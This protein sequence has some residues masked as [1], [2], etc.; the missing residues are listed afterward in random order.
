MT[1]TAW[2]D[3]LP[4]DGAGVRLVDSPRVRDA[5]DAAE[6]TR[7]LAAI[8]YIVVPA[9]QDMDVAAR[10]RCA[11][12]HV[13]LI[14]DDLVTPAAV[15]WVRDLT[16]A[17]P[18]AHLV[19]R[20]EEEA[21]TM[22]HERALAWPA[23]SQSSILTPR[24]DVRYRRAVALQ[25]AGRHDAARTWW[26]A[27][28]AAAAR[29]G[30]DAQYARAV[31]ACGRAA[32]EH[33]TADVLKRICTMCRAALGRITTLEARA[34]VVE[35][36]A[37]A[38]IRLGELEWTES[39][40]AGVR[41]ECALLD[42]EVPSSISTLQADVAMWQGRWSDAMAHVRSMRATSAAA[43]GRAA[44]IAWL[45][46]DD[47]EMR[48]VEGQQPDTPAPDSRD[49]AWL[50]LAHLLAAA[51]RGDVAAVRAG[52][53]VVARESHVLWGPAAAVEALRQVGCADD[54][55]VLLRQAETALDAGPC[56]RALL[57]HLAG[58][59]DAA[60]RIARCGAVGIV[61]WGKR[62]EQMTMWGGVSA[63]LDDVN[64]A[65]DDRAAIR[66]G[67]RW[68][69]THTG[70]GRVLVLAPDREQPLV[71]DPE[72]AV[73]GDDDVRA[74][75]RQGGVTIG[76]VVAARRS[77]DAE[78]LAGC[79]KTLAAVCAP[80]VRACLDVVRVTETGASLMTDLLGHS[81]AMGAL[82]AA[83]ARAAPTTFPVLIEGE[84]GVGKE[85]VA[86]A[87]HRLSARRDR[88]LAALNC[89][90]LTDELFEAELFG[91]TRGAF[92][93]AVGVRTGLFE[94]AHQGTLFLDE[95]G[96]L[97]PRAQAKLLRVL[98][99]GEVRRV[100]DNQTRAVDVRVVSATNRSLAAV[101][102]QGQY[103]E[104]L[105]F[106]LAVVRITVPPLRDRVEDIPGLAQTFWA[107]ATQHRATRA[108][109]TPDGLAALCRHAWP[110]NVRELQN[111]MAGLVLAAPD[112]G[113]VTAR[114]VAAVLEGAAAGHTTPPGTPLDE[115]R[116]A[117]DR[118]LVVA[119]LA[120]HAGCRAAAARD[121]GVSR[122]G[123]AKLMARLAVPTTGVATEADLR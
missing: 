60:V 24:P 6:R 67:C 75:I 116:R 16:M 123:L 110:G 96:E 1:W 90:A 38:S 30:D 18:R 77:R 88:R 65:E 102:A 104:D 51:A 84:S 72:G 81:P 79:V 13:A 111:V 27:A 82:R 21:P 22:V 80:A 54:A 122:Q 37:E 7:A 62:R 36:W 87:L 23:Q 66:R 42:R 26:Q 83:I 115:A 109:L 11:H 9:T 4:T 15:Q 119:A 91:H 94:D 50:R 34:R 59:A 78:A 114:H 68:V 100:G 40:L 14:V 107:R 12:Q 47:V 52:A 53:G 105:V 20:T 103:R 112:R 73:P 56:A 44:L 8:G 3:Q 118:Q 49:A 63:L 31:W 46:R 28:V 55:Q 69:R 108:W 71:A 33:P 48:R 29:R 39:W 2:A 5:S 32:L 41:V 113:R 95:V 61:H 93:G 58:E 101:A 97:S 74:P 64:N 57:A 43:M 25:R 98:Q 89:A 117:L 45:R 70:T 106:R 17:S 121:L 19:V 120:R 92:T 35:V 99:E 85:L 76:W 86:R 10:R